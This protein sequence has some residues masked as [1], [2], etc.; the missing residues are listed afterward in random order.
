MADAAGVAPLPLSCIHKKSAG[1]ASNNRQNAVALGPTWLMRTKTGAK[2]MPKAPRNRALSASRA[3]PIRGAV[4]E[5]ST[6][7]VANS[8]Y[9]I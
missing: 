8:R 2:A 7:E 1:R 4:V 5:R 6:L 9:Y 3:P